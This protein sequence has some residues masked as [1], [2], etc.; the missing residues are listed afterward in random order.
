M[1]KYAT[2]GVGAAMLFALPMLG[3][4]AERTITA[5]SL[6]NA[7]KTQV[8]ALDAKIATAQADLKVRTSKRGGEMTKEVTDDY[9]T[10]LQAKRDKQ[11][12]D[13]TY[14]LLSAALQ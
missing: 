10:I 3:V 14:K 9:T 7:Y 4:A 6:D 2:I 8:A 13:V 1:N 5:S 12:L 11:E